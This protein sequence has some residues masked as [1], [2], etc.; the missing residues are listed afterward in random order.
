MFLVMRCNNEKDLSILIVNRE[1][2]K[3]FL[4][5]KLHQEKYICK[6]KIIVV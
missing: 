4:Q 2:L 5:E 1:F 3:V 6:R